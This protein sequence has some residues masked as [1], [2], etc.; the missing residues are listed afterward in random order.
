MKSKLLRI[1]RREAEMKIYVEKYPHLLNGRFRVMQDGRC[2]NSCRYYVGAL[3]SA[4]KFRR[5]YILD[6]LKK[7][8]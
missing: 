7:L 6:K 1:L 3:N 4:N 2:I 5:A 8:E